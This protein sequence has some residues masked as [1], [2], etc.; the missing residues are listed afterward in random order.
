VPLRAEVWPVHVPSRTHLLSREEI[1][2]THYRH[3]RQGWAI[4][5]ADNVV[6]CHAPESVI[7]TA[8]EVVRGHDNL[9]RSV[10]AYFE[11]YRDTTIEVERVVY[12][13]NFLAISQT[14]T[15]T[16]QKTGITVSD[17]DLNI[18]IMQDGKFY[19]WREYYDSRKSAQTVEQTVFGN[20]A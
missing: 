1:L 14:W 13:G 15:C 4:G 9:R 3:T 18:G 8:F 12:D 11:N 6:S 19:R 5:S 7:Q 16:N 10:K 17:H 20:K 2:A